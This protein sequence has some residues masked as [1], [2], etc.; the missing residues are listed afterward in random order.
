[1]DIQLPVKD[2]IEATREIRELER[3][4]NVG[5]FITTPTTDLN[6]PSM[7]S[8]SNPL[9]NPSSPLLHMPVIIVAL[10]ASSLQADRVNALAAGCNDF[11]TKPVSLPW[12]ETKLVEWGSMAYLSGFSRKT[13]TSESL[14]A[15][16]T[17]TAPQTQ[18]QGPAATRFSAGI[19][20]KA[21]EVRGHLHIDRGHRSDESPE[22]D[23]NNASPALD[24][25][26]PVNTLS[27][28][29]AQPSL[30]L[31]SPT[32]QETPA[33]K[34]KQNDKVPDPAHTLAKVEEKLEE[35]VTEKEENGSSPRRPGPTPLPP[36][37]VDSQDPSLNDVL[38]E[39][40]RLAEFGRARTG[41]A[42]FGQVSSSCILQTYSFE[43]KL[44]STSST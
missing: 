6:S 13:E 23:S 44:N 26:P 40:A 30:M 27:D 34:P 42:S 31:T 38:V 41:S 11:L 16:V 35:L 24:A 9:S 7:S 18:S 37:V 32:P 28:A 20:S 8:I 25:G 2:G 10:T 22:I 39:G 36:T 1:M 15:A 12:L 17:L 14:V 3:A 21:D 33:A 4:N 5:T 29:A 43:C 19:N